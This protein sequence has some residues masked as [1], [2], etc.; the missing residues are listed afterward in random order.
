MDDASSKLKCLHLYS[1][2]PLQYATG[3]GCH[4]SGPE[5]TASTGR[6]SFEQ[7]LHDKGQAWRLILATF[8]NGRQSSISWALT[9]ELSWPFLLDTAYQGLKQSISTEPVARFLE[10]LLYSKA[11]RNKLIW[12]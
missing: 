8:L 7:P 4:H 12:Q 10:L 2:Y 3:A 1:V 6:L 5:P 11:D 9:V